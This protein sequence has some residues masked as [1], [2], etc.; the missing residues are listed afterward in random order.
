MAGPPL[1]QTIEVN[2]YR[3]EVIDSY[4]NAT[5]E[6]MKQFNEAKK[7]KYGQNQEDNNQNTNG[8]QEETQ[9]EINVKN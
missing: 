2:K 5:D 7:Q 1:T 8:N 3:G 9:E 4:T 6:E